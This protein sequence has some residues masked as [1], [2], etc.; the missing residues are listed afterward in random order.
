MAR[1]IR[2]NAPGAGEWI[3]KHVEGYFSPG[4]DHSFSTHIGDEILGGF[5][6]GGYLGASA[7]VH[8]AAQAIAWCSRDLLWMTFNYAFKQLGCHKLFAPVRSD[9]HKALEQDIR[10]GWQIEAVLRD[11]YAKSVHMIVLSMTEETCPWLSI[12]PQGWQPGDQTDG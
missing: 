2:I 3:M 8:M 5:V 9:N 1:E 4:W 7:T 12:H 10:A 11:A 6:V